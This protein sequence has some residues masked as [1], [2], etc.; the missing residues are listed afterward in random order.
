MFDHSI[1]LRK[2]E[3]METALFYFVFVY[4]ITLALKWRQE[5]RLKP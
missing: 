3:V 5:G 4:L 1:F 2:S